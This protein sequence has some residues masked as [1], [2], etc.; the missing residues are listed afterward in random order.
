MMPLNDIGELGLRLLE[1]RK[2]IVG[3]VG[4]LGVAAG[5][6]GIKQPPA[7]H[8]R[9]DVIR[10]RALGEIEKRRDMPDGDRS[11]GVRRLQNGCGETGSL[12]Q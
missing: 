12:H 7:G 8:Q 1:S 3:V 2:I 10:S 6:P 5:E 11:I 4:V 9:L